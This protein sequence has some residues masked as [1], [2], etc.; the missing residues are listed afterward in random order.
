MRIKLTSLL[1]LKFRVHA[2]L[3]HPCPLGWESFSRF[4]SI[5][6]APIKTPAPALHP[7]MPTSCQNTASLQKKGLYCFSWTI[8]LACQTHG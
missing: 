2:I 6:I 3:P 4:F 5:F 1:Y 8:V 7:A